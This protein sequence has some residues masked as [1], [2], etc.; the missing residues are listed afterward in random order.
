MKV[1]DLIRE[2]AYPE[3]IG[4]IVDVRKSNKDFSYLTATYV[5]L[6]QRGEVHWFDAEYIENDC[7]VINE[8]R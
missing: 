7:E 4:L 3:D 6:N 8:S 1:G 2:P 5:V